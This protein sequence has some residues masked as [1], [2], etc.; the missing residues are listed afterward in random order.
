[1]AINIDISM[2]KIFFGSLLNLLKKKCIIIDVYKDYV[3]VNAI[4]TH[5]IVAIATKMKL[6]VISYI[7]TDVAIK[8]DL[9]PIK[10]I[11]FCCV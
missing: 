9:R 4:T 5:S 6:V 7:L 8:W 11:F 10:Y 2:K 1:M 3:I